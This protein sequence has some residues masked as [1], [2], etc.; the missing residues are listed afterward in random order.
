MAGELDRSGQGQPEIGSLNESGLMNA[1]GEA[2]CVCDAQGT[3]AWSNELFRHYG[4]GVAEKVR[5]FC[6][7]AAVEFAQLW[8]DH[9]GENPQKRRTY[10]F[11]TDSDHRHFKVKIAPLSAGPG[12][13]VA[14]VV[15]EVTKH[16]RLKQK[17]SSINRAGRELVHIE[18]EEVRGLHAAE[19]LRVLETK[20]TRFAHELLSFDHYAVRLMSPET[21][22]LDLAMS[23]GLTP[24]ATQVE[25]YAE[26]ENNG[27]SGYVAATGKSYVCRDVTKDRRYVV[28]MAHA[29]SSLTVPLRLFDRV[30]GVFNVESDRVNAFNAMD[31]QFAE[32][33]ASHLAMALHILNLLVTE[34]CATS[35][36]AT[37]TMQGELNEP[38]NDLAVEAEWLREQAAADP[39]ATRHIDRIV[40]DVDSIRRRMQNLAKGPGTLLGVDEAIRQGRLDPALSGGRILVAD[41]DEHVVQ[42]IRDVLASRGCEVIAYDT[43]Q[44]AIDR[45]EAAAHTG[46]RFHLVLSDINLGDRTG[47]EVFSAARKLGGDVPVIL[48]TGFGYDPHHS[49]VRASQEGLQCVLFKPFQA[50]KLVDEA[51]V[52]VVKMKMAR[53]GC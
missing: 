16:E 53:V 23:A 24:E 28:G 49:I 17:I 32:M 1:L 15:V 21:R 6:R 22:K 4:T 48:M 29:G 12:M 36:L 38:L 9:D 41:N 14:A 10:R 35:E 33:F 44:A 26:G 43:G 2:A 30:I 37:G 19:R 5:E 47:Y 13:R 42:T 31:Q 46:E 40:R 3:V 50:E 45:L 20:V 51:R 25:L 39:E 52:A 8:G 34:R 27:I 18:T 11:V 7:E